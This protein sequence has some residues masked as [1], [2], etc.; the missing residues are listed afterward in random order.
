M[1]ETTDPRDAATA[2]HRSLNRMRAVWPAH[3]WAEAEAEYRRVLRRIG[4]PAE[5]ERVVDAFI[6]GAQER[7]PP[8]PGVLVSLATSRPRDAERREPR[9]LEASE[10]RCPRCR[11]E[12][13]SHKVIVDANGWASCTEG[14]HRQVW[15]VA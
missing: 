2:V 4:D 10:S 5:I 8:P 9:V 15:K 12:G 7:F 6:D 13:L 14:S 3:R 11:E 1:V